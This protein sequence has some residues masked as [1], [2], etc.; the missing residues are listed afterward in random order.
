MGG[1][2]M[3]FTIVEIYP[4]NASPEKKAETKKAYLKSLEKSEAQWPILDAEEPQAVKEARQALAGVWNVSSAVYNGHAA[5]PTGLRWIFS[6]D[7]VLLDTNG[8]RLR[9]TYRIDTSHQPAR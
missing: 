2:G 9:G 8:R 4:A 6:E 1:A 3:Q 7:K 5:H